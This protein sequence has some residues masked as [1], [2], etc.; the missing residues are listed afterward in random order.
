M[1]TLGCINPSGYCMNVCVVLCHPSPNSY[2]PSLVLNKIIGSSDIP[3][4]LSNSF[5]KNP[6]EIV[7]RSFNES[8]RYIS[9][10]KNYSRGKKVI[11]LIKNLKSS[12]KRYKSTLSGCI[13]EKIGDSVII[14]HEN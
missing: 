12:N 2:L 4:I 9:S 14:S 5:F 13:I 8:L 7:F 1:Y 6:D 11:E 10:R 3:L